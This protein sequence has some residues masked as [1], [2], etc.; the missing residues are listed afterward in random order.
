MAVLWRLSFL[1][2]GYGIYAYF[3]QVMAGSVK[4]QNTPMT[5]S[6]ESNF[7]TLAGLVPTLDQQALQVQEIGLPS[8]QST[9][10][11]SKLLA[12][13]ILRFVSSK[14]N[15]SVSFRTTIVR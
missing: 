3:T 11:S 14:T 12:E 5:E 10:P 4:M 2:S 9:C 13:V 8:V 1:Y 15:Q 6:T 7:L